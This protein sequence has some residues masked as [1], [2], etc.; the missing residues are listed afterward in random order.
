[1]S[2]QTKNLYTGIIILMLIFV[3]TIAKADLP[4]YNTLYELPIPIELPAGKGEIVE[5]DISIGVGDATT[6]AKFMTFDTM[7]NVNK[8]LDTQSNL[9]ISFSANGTI[10]VTAFAEIVE[11][12]KWLQGSTYDGIVTYVQNSKG[13]TVSVDFS[14][15]DTVYFKYPHGVNYIKYT[16][17]E[18]K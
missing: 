5:F 1:M 8:P 6:S 17:G 12:G 18:S 13:L 15:F 11:I 7:P 9:S 4:T 14:E 16:F 10:Y 3:A 2:A